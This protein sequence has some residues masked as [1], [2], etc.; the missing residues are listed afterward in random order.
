MNEDRWS[1]STE[2]EEDYNP[3]N[4]G[5]HRIPSSH[6]PLALGYIQPLQQ[7]LDKWKTDSIFYQDFIY[8][9]PFDNEVTKHMITKLET[10]STHKTWGY[11]FDYFSTTYTADELADLAYEAL[12]YLNEDEF[13]LKFLINHHYTYMWPKGNNFCDL[14]LPIPSTLLY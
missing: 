3:L 4:H 5:K 14:S 11:L 12:C 7:Y 6:E 13:Y 2:E 10:L 8:S 1:W 9:C